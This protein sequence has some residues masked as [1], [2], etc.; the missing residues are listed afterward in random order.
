[1]HRKIRTVAAIDRE[2]EFPQPEAGKCCPVA[3][4]DPRIRGVCDAEFGGSD[5]GPPHIAQGFK[6]R[7]GVT[8]R[9]ARTEDR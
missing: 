4:L 7:P 1:V 6:N 3:F 5:K 9:N 2:T 8:Q